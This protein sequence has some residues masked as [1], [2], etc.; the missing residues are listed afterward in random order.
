[1]DRDVAELVDQA[2]VAGAKP[3]VAAELLLRLLRHAP[4]AGEHVRPLDL[5]RPDRPRPHRLPVAADDA[6]ADAR[7]RK[8]DR[9][10]APLAVPRVVRIRRQHHRLAHP[11]ALED[12]V[13]GA[14]A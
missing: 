13:A 3:A 11:V 4:V 6:P 10:A 7:E 8:A 14:L 5:D 2:D 9:A 1:D 12:G